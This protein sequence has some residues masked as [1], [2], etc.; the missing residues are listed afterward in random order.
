MCVAGLEVD[1]VTIL[2]SLQRMLALLTG[3]LRRDPPGDSGDPYA[4]QAVP[5]RPG[6]SPRRD[7]VAVAEPDDE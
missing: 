5:R 1:V 6:P 7:A 4:R 2:S 3:W